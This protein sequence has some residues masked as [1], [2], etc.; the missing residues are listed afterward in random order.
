MLIR[1]NSLTKLSK[2][3]QECENT[4]KNSPCIWKNNNFFKRY[5]LIVTRRYLREKKIKIKYT[6]LERFLCFICFSLLNVSIIHST[7][8]ILCRCNKIKFSDLWNL[9]E[10]DWYGAYMSLIIYY[11][12][13][14]IFKS[15]LKSNCAF[16]NSFFVGNNVGTHTYK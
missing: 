6:V 5:I 11:N 14:S 15:R 12:L 1:L 13:I 4:W 2:I 8:N 9:T 3:Y 16:C 10:W 7:C